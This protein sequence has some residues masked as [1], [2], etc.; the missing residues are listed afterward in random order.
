MVRIGIAAGG[1]VVAG[2]VLGAL[3]KVSMDGAKRTI[4]DETDLRV[5]ATRGHSIPSTRCIARASAG[6]AL[7]V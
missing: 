1:A 4:E 2:V 6:R 7:S 3:L 5:R